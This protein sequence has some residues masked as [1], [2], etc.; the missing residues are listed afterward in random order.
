M[1]VNLEYSTEYNKFIQHEKAIQSFFKQNNINKQ[2]IQYNNFKQ[3]ADAK[4]FVKWQHTTT[5]D[6]KTFNKFIRHWITTKGNVK[7][8]WLTKINKM[9]KYYTQKEQNYKHK[10][11]R[12]TLRPNSI[13]Q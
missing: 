2:Y 13:K 6:A 11:L 8:S 12:V 1:K 10:L 7:T 3:Y 5:K 4:H 9:L